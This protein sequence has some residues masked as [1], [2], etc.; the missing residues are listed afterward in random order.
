MTN[1]QKRILVDLRHSGLGYRKIAARLGISENT[2]KGYIRRNG[3]T[4]TSAAAPGTTA[5]YCPQC[6][7]QIEG[8]KGKKFCGEPCR[9]AWWKANNS[10]IDRRAWYDLV[11]AGCGRNFRSYG[12]DKRKYCDHG[13]YI[14]DRFERGAA[15]V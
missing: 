8:R 5:G 2:V 9:R 6:G 12:N 4:P 7:S 1:E 10:L 14:R 3:I 15:V 13:C 11:C